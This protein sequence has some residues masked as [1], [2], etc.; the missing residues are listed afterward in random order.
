M[1]NIVVSPKSFFLPDKNYFIIFI[2]ALACWGQKGAPT[3][4]QIYDYL[5]DNTIYPQIALCIITVS[6]VSPTHVAFKE[7]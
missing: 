1:W 2:S 5:E 6:T 7:L 3:P 4:D